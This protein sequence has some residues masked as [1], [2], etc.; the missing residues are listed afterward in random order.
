MQ[1]VEEEEGLSFL[2]RKGSVKKG[3]LGR[4][5]L[6]TLL[7]REYNGCKKFKPPKKPTYNLLLNV[8]NIF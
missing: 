8:R 7:V 3:F 6:P 2:S 5:F 4:K 1:K